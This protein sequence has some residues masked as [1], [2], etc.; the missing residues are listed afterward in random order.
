[1]PSIRIPKNSENQ[2]YFITIVVH[3]WIYVLDRFDRWD[4]LLC[5]LRYFIKNRNLKVFAWVFMINH[6]HL[7]IYSEDP[8]AFVRDFKK[9]TSK[10]IKKNMLFY[11]PMVI[12]NFIDSKGEYAF[13]TKTNMPKAIYTEKYFY[14]KRLYIENNPVKRR[15]VKKSEDWVYSSANEEELIKLSYI[16]E[17]GY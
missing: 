9:F 14:Q 10:Q 2:P 3:N 13:W 12:N 11:E 7:I 6:I 16:E 17:L 4:I 5:S 15:Y 1:M 8:I